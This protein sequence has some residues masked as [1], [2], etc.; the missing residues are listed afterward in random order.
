MSGYDSVINEKAKEVVQQHF[1]ECEFVDI[2]PFEAS[3]EV[4][5]GMK[6]NPILQIKNYNIKKTKTHKVLMA[7]NFICQHC[8]HEAMYVLIMKR[9]DHNALVCSFLIHKNNSLVP[10]TKDHIIAKALKGSSAYSNLQTLCY[11]C[12][13]EKSNKTVIGATVDNKGKN[14]NSSGKPKITIDREEYDELTRKSRDFYR[15]RKNIKLTIKKAPWYYKVL[16]ID[17]YI[18]KHL[19]RPLKNKGYFKS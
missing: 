15:L 5:E 17:Q 10:L 19:K 16:G 7:D 4:I 18:E 8:V 14:K 11:D 2:L 3:D 6:N 12:N 9:N 13:Q 1:N